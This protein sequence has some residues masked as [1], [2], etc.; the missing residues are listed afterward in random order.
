LHVADL[1]EVKRWLIGFGSEA[2]VLVPG[3]LRDQISAEADRLLKNLRSRRV[4]NKLR[5]G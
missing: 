5:D 1:D 4:V 3:S 2:T